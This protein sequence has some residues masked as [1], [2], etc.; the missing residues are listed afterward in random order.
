[1]REINMQN[2]LEHSRKIPAKRDVLKRLK[3]FRE[4]Y[5]L[6]DDRNA[7]IQASRCVQCGNPYCH[8]ACPLSNFIPFWLEKLASDD[9][10]FAFKIS[11]DSS[12]FPEIMGRVC[13]QDR[14]CEGGCTLNDGFGA[15][16]IGSIETFITEKGFE[17]GLSIDVTAKKSAKKVAI[18]G[19]GP[20]GL[21]AATFLLRSGIE[22]EMFE[23][24]DRAGGLLTYGIPNFK[25]DKSVVQRRVDL[26]LSYGMKLHLN[27]EVGKDIELNYLTEN[28]DAVFVA[29]GA[30]KAKA[31]EVENA[32]LNG[33]YDAMKFLTDVQKSNFSS[34]HNKAIDVKDKKVVVI[35]AG[36]TAMDC[37]RSAVREGA[38]EVYCYYRRDKASMP[39]SKKE[40]FN[41]DEEGVEFV[42]NRAPVSIDG[43]ESVKSVTFA[44]TE[45]VDS[46]VKIIENSQEIVEADIV[47]K[48][49]GF[50]VDDLSYLSDIELDRWGSPVVN[51]LY[52]T[53]NDKIYAGGDCIRGADLV[54][55]A[56]R[57]G[58]DAAK[59]ITKKL[60]G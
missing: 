29:V 28:F 7:N 47:I 46:R 49:L 13:P 52:Q 8:N 11:N 18:V 19:S 3:D 2:F 24:D 5:K 55:T 16:T 44:K 9:L 36:D 12:P 39:G 1:M 35:G 33:V 15:V 54:V 60:L 42:F 32:D 34:N 10:E 53:S 23:R 43:D 27:S 6:F 40:S 26:L 58:R 22:V 30:T 45:I 4:I 38:K 14:L 51:K 20:A 41:A 25:L 17:S 50:D 59:A 48:S 21:S 37:V 31:L 56:A 57:D